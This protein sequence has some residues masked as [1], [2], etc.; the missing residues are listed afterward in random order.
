MPV[1]VCP[2]D[3]PASWNA[4]LASVPGA[5]FQQSWQWGELAPDLGGRVT[6]LA[7]V[8]GGSMVAAMQLFAF[9]VGATGL[10]YLYVPRGPALRRPSLQVVA[11]LLEA[12]RLVGGRTGAIGIRLEPN[13]H[14]CDVEWKR[15]LD[16]LGLR[17]AYPPSQPRSSW[18]LDIGGPAEDL[19]IGMKQKT[20]YNI[21]LA[22][23]KGVEVVEGGPSDLDAFYDLYRQTAARDDF[24]AHGKSLYARMFSLFWDADSFCLLLA[25]Y[26]D[27]LL[28]AITLVRLGTT[29]WYLH[30]ASGNEHRNL[31]APHLLQWRG[32]EWARSRG[33]TRY[34]FRA[35]P[36]A[37]RDDQD[38]YGVYRFKAGFGGRHDTV[39]HT[40][41][42]SYRPWLF[43]LWQ[44]WFAGRFAAQGWRRRRQGLPARQFA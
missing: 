36:D 11:P 8:E 15:C 30:G 21:R 26:R 16:S 32:I 31:M 17:P 43:G 7:A 22:E 14:S 40:Y 3:D 41:A 39:L 42:A 25:R 4:F 34:D 37:L 2:W 19:L 6:R 29:C 5:H 23:R 27:Q 1:T 18:V 35:V 13:A 38:M 9:P 33:C 20:R 24:F 10:T 28:A 12:A 44:L